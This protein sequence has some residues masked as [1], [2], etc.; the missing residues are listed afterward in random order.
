MGSI[1]LQACIRDLG[2]ESKVENYQRK[3]KN[4]K[5]FAGSLAKPAASIHKE[6]YKTG[7][8]QCRCMYAGLQK[9]CGILIQCFSPML[10]DKRKG[11]SP[12]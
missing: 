3:S 9:T 12:E 8:S 2:E 6:R 10:L 5:N 4:Q 7:C 11:K 1:E